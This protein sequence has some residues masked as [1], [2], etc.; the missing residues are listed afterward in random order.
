M[1][2]YCKSCKSEY[3]VEK[4]KLIPQAYHHLGK[5]K[6]YCPCCGNSEAPPI[7]IPDHE[8][9]EQRVKRTGKPVPEETAVFLYRG[10]W[11]RDNTKGEDV[12]VNWRWELQSLKDARDTI[13]RKYPARY[14]VIA[15]PPTPPKDVVLDSVTIDGVHTSLI[16]PEKRIRGM[17]KDIFLAIG[18]NPKILLLGWAIGLLTGFGIGFAVIAGIF[19]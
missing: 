4:R 18:Q 8:T 3:T 11:H 12:A 15:D 7:L 10:D 6:E 9:I 1:K 19:L 13:S 5:W 16:I 14:M 2:C 17:G